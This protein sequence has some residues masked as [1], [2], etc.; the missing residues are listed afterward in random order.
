MGIVTLV[1]GK[2]VMRLIDIVSL[3]RR[4]Q[5]GAHTLTQGKVGSPSVSM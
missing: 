1:C 3:E 4:T 5:I 2:S